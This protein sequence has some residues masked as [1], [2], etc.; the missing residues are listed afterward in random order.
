[1]PRVAPLHPPYDET[2]GP[3]LAA[4]MPPGQAPIALFRVFAINPAMTAAMRG[5][6]GYELGRSLSLSLRSREIAIDR[7]CARCRCE[8]EWGVHVAHFG[9][10]AGLDRRQIASL[11]HGGAD[12]PCWTDPAER[13][14]IRVMDHLHDHGDLDDAH[15]TELS[16][17]YGDAQILDLL[18]LT[19]WYR[20]ISH[21]ANA[22]RLDPEPGAPRFAD[23][24]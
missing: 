18:L 7:T 19:G 2:T 12:D 16:D 9:E 4:M 15:W 1:M 10:R 11:T 13:A 6:G 22:I 24:L 23:Y 14:L 21:T 3:L 5:W 20:A 17:H 8:Y